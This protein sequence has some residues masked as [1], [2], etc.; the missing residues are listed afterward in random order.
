MQATCYNY[1]LLPNTNKRPGTLQTPRPLP[2]THRRLSPVSTPDDTPIDPAVKRCARCGETKPLAEMVRSSRSRDGY[3]A[4]CKACH[5]AWNREIA[6]RDPEATRAYGREKAMRLYRAD[7]DKYRARHRD[8]YAENREHCV[9]YV[10]NYYKQRPEKKRE[11]DRNYSRR[12]SAKIVARVKQW[13][14]DNPERTKAHQQANKA[15][16]RGAG[17]AKTFDRMMIWERDG[18]RC[19]IC[20][21]KC[22]PKA[23]DMD[24]LTPLSK[25]GSHAPDNVAVSHPSCNR[26]RSNSG[27]AQ[28]RLSG[29]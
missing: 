23:W 1:V 5:N 16:R 25:G 28:L 8:W 14:I 22:D 29:V 19:H 17:E 18:G 3:L 21:K 6:D 27:P 7:P 4:R 11:H 12:H 24:H 15:K 20:G 13:Q 9:S 2:N 26:R 10:A